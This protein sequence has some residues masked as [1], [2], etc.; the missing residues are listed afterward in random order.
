M[1]ASMPC[2]RHMQGAVVVARGSSLLEYALL[3]AAVL[4]ALIAMQRML[5]GAAGGMARQA[6]DTFGSGQQVDAQF[7][8]DE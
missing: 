3:L 6:G 2:A 8:P 4:T 7:L 5:S 1:N